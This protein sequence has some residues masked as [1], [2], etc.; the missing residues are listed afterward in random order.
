MD[1]VVMLQILLRSETLATCF[2][3]ERPF[4]YMKDET[5]T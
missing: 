2:T 3:H 4:T 1:S 5:G